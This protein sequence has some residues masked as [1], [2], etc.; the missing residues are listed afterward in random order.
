MKF[1]TVAVRHGVASVPVVVNFLDH[2]VADLKQLGRFGYIEIPGTTHRD[3]LEPLV[4][5]DHA[6]PARRAGVGMLDGSH[7]DPVFTRQTDG[8][9]LDPRVLQLRLKDLRGF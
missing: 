6:H 4:S 5:H 2:A 8:R 3:G 9:H 1:V 7:E